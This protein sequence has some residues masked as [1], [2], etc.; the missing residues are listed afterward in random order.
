MKC[1]MSYTCPVVGLDSNSSA[2]GIGMGRLSPCSAI[3]RSQMT[4]FSKAPECLSFASP[5][6]N[7]RVFAS[8]KLR[9][10]IL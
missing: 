1:R 7:E 8:V 4:D 9:D 6:L 10:L 2:C 3:R 5:P